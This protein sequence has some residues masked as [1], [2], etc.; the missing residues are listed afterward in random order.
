M[1]AVVFA[2]LIPNFLTAKVSWNDTSAIAAMRNLAAA[3]AT[4]AKGRSIDVDRD[5]KGEYGTLSE[6]TGAAGPRLDGEGRLRGERVDPAVLSTSLSP[7]DEAGIAFRSGYCFRIL[8]P[9]TGGGP[10]RESTPGSPFTAPVDVDAAERSWAAYAWP[11]ARYAALKG[12]SRKHNRVL[13]ADG[14]GRLWFT[15]NDDSRYAGSG[16][17]PSW[18]AAMPEDGWGDGWADPPAGVEEYRGRDGNTWRDIETL[19]RR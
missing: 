6:L 8:L 3:Q 16:G 5:G 12:E 11:A 7:V 10:S 1:L 15:W 17:G 2:M 14:T 4:C 13:F 19:F 18:D 9:A